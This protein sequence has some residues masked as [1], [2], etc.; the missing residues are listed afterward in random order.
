LK[1]HFAMTLSCAGSHKV[2]A[3]FTEN[4]PRTM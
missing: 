4:L 2:K 3:H 1:L